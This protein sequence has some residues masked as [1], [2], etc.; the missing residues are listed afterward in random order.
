MREAVAKFDI[1]AIADI[2]VSSPR[3]CDPFVLVLFGGT[4]DLARRKLIPALYHLC[5]DGS[6]PENFT[7]IGVSRSATTAE[8]FQAFHRESLERFSRTHPIEA[9]LWNRFAPTLTCMSGDINR[10]ETY[11]E[12]QERLA[13]SD[14]TRGTKGNRLF[15]FATPSSAFPVILRGLKEAG[16]LHKYVAAN[17]TLWS[18]VIVEKPFGHDVESARE[19]NRLAL[20]I[21]DERQ[22][23]RIDHYLG[24]ETVQ[25]ILVFRFGNAIFEPLWNRKYIDHVQITAAEDIGVEGRGRFYDETGVLRDV[26]QN[27]LLEILSFIAM[28]PPVSFKADEIRDQKVQVYRSLRALFG[29]AIQRQVVYAQYRGYRE[30]SNVSPTSR[31]PTYAA[32]KV[33]IDNWRWQGVP[34]YLR[35]GKRLYRRATEVAVFFQPIPHCLFGR[36]DVCRR[37]DP[38]VLTLRI[39]PNEGISLRFACK[40]PG[41][42]L[43]VGNVK[44]DFHYAGGFDHPSGEAYERLLLDGLRGDLTLFSRK[45][46]IEYAWEFVTPVLQAWESNP[47]LPISTYD[48]GSPGPREA[49]QLLAHDG[50]RWME[51]Q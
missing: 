39:Q 31:T 35:A 28:E 23:F 45:D 3:T 37:V 46:A 8:A 6:L 32:L 34:F 47:Q 43:N 12:L 29:D 17:D 42:E 18:R 33:L 27:H 15:Y 2:P 24:K 5:R 49:D 48:P 21:L 41:D 13:V 51:N 4:G 38:N 20:A 19:L 11:R 26:V 10:P 9:D 30:E 44:M 14:Q 36:E 7:V 50:R 16:L 22:I 40:I 1:P 25:N